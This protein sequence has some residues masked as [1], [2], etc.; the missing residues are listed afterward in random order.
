MKINLTLISSAIVGILIMAGLFYVQHL[1]NA[2]SSY[3]K[4]S[5]ESRIHIDDFNAIQLQLLK[6]VDEDLE[7]DDNH[8]LP[9]VPIG[10]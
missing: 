10:L 3:E 8:T 2:L 1:Q 4:K 9:A 5:M 7:I 6:D